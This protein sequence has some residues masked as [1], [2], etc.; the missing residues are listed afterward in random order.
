MCYRVTA[1]IATLVDNANHTNHKC[2]FIYHNR[3]TRRINQRFYRISRDFNRQRQWLVFIR[4]KGEDGLPWEPKTGDTVCSDHFLLKKKSNLS[5]NSEYV[6]SVRSTQDFPH[7]NEGA[8]AC[9]KHLESCHSTQ[10][11]N[12]KVKKLQHDKQDRKS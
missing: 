2:S 4:R 6:P 8:V 10:K 9:F 12:K 3:Q 1:E 5:T 11:A 7:M